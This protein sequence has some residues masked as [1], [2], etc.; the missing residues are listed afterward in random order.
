[1]S[2][3]H[4]LEEMGEEEKIEFAGLPL[5]CYVPRVFGYLLHLDDLNMSSAF[6]V[7]EVFQNVH[8]HEGFNVRV[9]L[10]II[11]DHSRRFMIWIVR[12]KAHHA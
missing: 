9:I 4:H 3:G 8:Q 11:E 12:V 5:L 1:M 7:L 10:D 2:Y 6:E